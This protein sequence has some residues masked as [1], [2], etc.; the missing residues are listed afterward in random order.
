MIPYLIKSRGKVVNVSSAGHSL[1]KENESTFD[2]KK[3]TQPPIEGSGM[4]GALK[5]LGFTKLCGILHARQLHRLYFEKFGIASN[6]LNPGFLDASHD[7][8]PFELGM[9]N[10]FM[11]IVRW[12]FAKDLV[13]GA[14]TSVFVATKTNKSGEYF[15]NNKIEETTELAKSEKIS[16]E[17]WNFCEQECL[18]HSDYYQ[19]FLEKYLF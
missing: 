18:R 8:D 15:S 4:F 19:K 3:L 1:I 12:L 17:L 9:L 2:F 16:S 11:V 5:Q 6:A 14:Q 13:N 10:Y 7:Q